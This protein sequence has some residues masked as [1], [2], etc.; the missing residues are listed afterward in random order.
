[1]VE[2]TPESFQPSCVTCSDFHA[3][4][5]KTN[6]GLFYLFEPYRDDAAGDGTAMFSVNTGVFWSE[7]GGQSVETDPGYILRISM[8]L[9]TVGRD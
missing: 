9:R 7:A 8:I 1:M 6:R 3:G 4:G 5:L 2:L